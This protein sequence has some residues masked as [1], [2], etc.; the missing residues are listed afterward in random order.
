LAHYLQHPHTFGEHIQHLSLIHDNPGH[1]LELPVGFEP[2]KILPKLEGLTLTH[3]NIKYCLR[4]AFLDMLDTP[5]LTHFSM[6]GCWGDNN[7]TTDLGAVAQGTGVKLEHLALSLHW[8]S[9]DKS[10]TVET[11]LGDLL[12]ASKY[13][14]SLHVQWYNP[15]PSPQSLV[16]KIC[17]IGPRLELL[18]LHQEMDCQIAAPLS[19][20]DF[21]AICKS[22]P[23]LRQIGIQFFEETYYDDDPYGEL[24]NFIVSTDIPFVTIHQILIIK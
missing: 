2:T 10:G 17:T 11:Y 5:N 18:S 1:E 9:E 6:L 4:D 21:Q 7:Y 14:K 24:E 19:S 13:M 20:E 12:N 15:L 23:N 8:L 3:M 22:C 16:N